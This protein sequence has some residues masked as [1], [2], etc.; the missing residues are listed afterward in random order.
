M[1]AQIRAIEDMHRI[2]QVL[3]ASPLF[4]DVEVLELIDE[5]SVRLI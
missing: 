5:T 3:R 1:A 4:P 2:I